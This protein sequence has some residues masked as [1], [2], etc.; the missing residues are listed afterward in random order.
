MRIY[1]PTPVPI[2]APPGLGAWLAGELR[3]ISN[4]FSSDSVQLEARNAEPT[5]Y[6]DGMIVY[7]DGT[8]WNPGSGEG[9]Y[10][11]YGGA[12]NKL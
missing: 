9:I 7:A 2:N 4:A 12:W 3:R 6:R 11:R 5:R 8:N 10:A 1:T